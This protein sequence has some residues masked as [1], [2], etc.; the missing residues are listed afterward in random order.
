MPKE[1]KNSR[2]NIIRNATIASLIFIGI[3]FLF[4]SLVASDWNIFIKILIAI[5]AGSFLLPTLLI[6]TTI[7]IVFISTYLIDHYRK[8]TRTKDIAETDFSVETQVAYLRS[9]GFSITNPISLPKDI[10]NHRG[11]NKQSSV[12]ASK[13]NDTNA[14]IWFIYPKHTVVRY[15]TNQSTMPSFVINSAL[16]DDTP[17]AIQPTGTTIDLG[18]E[19]GKYISISAPK[20]TEL[21]VIQILD[22]HTMLFLLKYG[23]L[24]D[25]VIKQS[26]IDFVFSFNNAHSSLHKVY[27]QTSN[28]FSRLIERSHKKTN[29]PV[30]RLFVLRNESSIAIKMYNNWFKIIL[31]SFALFFLTFTTIAI[32][33]ENQTHLQVAVIII[34]MLFFLKTVLAL[35]VLNLLFYTH[36]GT[37]I[38]INGII[39]VRTYTLT[40]DY[41]SSV[42]SL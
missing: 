20:D 35:A 3:S 18:S 42:S 28:I 31:K 32:I 40:R 39:K 1:Q 36:L 21:E 6:S 26:S 37:N 33:P 38:I 30:N 29:P 12:V 17:S 34:A 14:P 15:I 23:A 16:N 9:M 11:A 24:F 25:T 8:I 13:P 5:L 10:P 4:V 2:K 7:T 27:E 22:P 19:F 41:K